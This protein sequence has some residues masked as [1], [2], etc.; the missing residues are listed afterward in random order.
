MPET[1]H[2]FYIALEG[3]EP[4][5]WRRIQVPSNYTFWDLH[6][7]IQDAMGWLD[8]HLHLFRAKNPDTGEIDQ[9]GIPD[10]DPFFDEPP[11][12]AGWDIP[13]AS[14][15]IEPDDTAIYQYDFGDDWTH[16]VKLEAV[17][18]PREG[19]RALACLAGERKCP[20]EDCGGA[21]GYSELLQVIADET[22]TNYEQMLQWLGGEFDPEAFNAKTVKFDDPEERWRIAFEDD[23]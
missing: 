8:Y 2:R 22:H 17:N 20:P 6:V 9:I 4:P 10:D 12:L 16:M 7:A 1:V 15:F 23:L 18:Q 21:F 13:I 3:V 11:C 19:G 5:V 14:Y